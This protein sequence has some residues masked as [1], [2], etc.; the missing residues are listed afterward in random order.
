MMKQVEVVARSQEQA[1]EKAAKQ[2]EMEVDD[3]DVLEEYEPDEI[4]LEDLAKDEEG[5][6][7]EEKQGEPVLYVV[8]ASAR[9]FIEKTQGWISDFISRFQPG[10]SCEIVA[11]NGQLRVIIEPTEASIL[12]GKQGQTLEAL[13]HIVW[14]VMSRMVEDCPQI[15]LDVGD[16]RAEKISRLEG[17]AMGAARRALRTGRDVPLRPM[18][19]QDR[20]F[21]HNLLKDMEGIRTQSQGREPRRYL[22]IEVEGR[23]GGGKGRRR[24]GGG[25]GRRRDDSDSRPPQ[26]QQ[27][28]SHQPPPP[29]EGEDTQYQ[30]VPIEERGSRMPQYQESEID[31]KLFDPERPLV[32][33]IE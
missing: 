29:D 8:Q 4:D 33:E 21:V 32:D 10:S 5:L 2:L 6:T 27:K 25:Q 26:T 17:Y 3:L 14:R 13:Q 20:K 30:D 12:I 9:G 19:S 22:V 31:E 28:R 24:G 15:V 16:Y 7:E 23:R 18:G 11:E 1:L